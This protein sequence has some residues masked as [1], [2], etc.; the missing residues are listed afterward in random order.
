MSIVP[1]K[2]LTIGALVFCV[3][4]AGSSAGAEIVSPAEFLAKRP[5]NLQLIPNEMLRQP[6]QLSVSF[7]LRDA[8][9]SAAA[10]AFLANLMSSMRALPGKADITLQRQVFPMR[11]HYVLTFLF[12]SWNDYVAHEQDP[13]VLKFYREQ[14]K[15]AV[16]EAEERLSVRDPSS[17][18]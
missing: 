12:E 13:A 10:N 7:S 17:T 15:P 3:A 2:Y 8:P 6:V 9:N 14:W 16:L 18:N 5:N 4:L 1:V 11:F